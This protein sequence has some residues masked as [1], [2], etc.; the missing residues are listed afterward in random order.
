MN[1]NYFNPKND[2]K[3]KNKYLIIV[4]RIVT[5][6]FILI[7]T[8]LISQKIITNLKE[9]R[10]EPIGELIEVEGKRVFTEYTDKSTNA[11]IVF[12]SDIGQPSSSWKNTKELIEKKSLIDG[13]PYYVASLIYDKPGYGHSDS[14]SK[15]D[16]LENYITDLEILLKKANYPQPY[17]LVG[18]GYGGLIAKHFAYKNNEKVSGMVLINT[19]NDNIINCGEMKYAL[20]QRDKEKFK[21]QALSMSGLLQFDIVYNKYRNLNESVYKEK[22]SKE[23][24]EYYQYYIR[25]N[26]TISSIQREIESLKTYNSDID[27]QIFMEKKPVVLI[28]SEYNGLFKVDNSEWLKIQEKNTSISSDVEIIND[29][30][31]GYM[32]PLTNPQIIYD[33]IVGVIKNNK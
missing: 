28:S 25:S 14:L 4:D 8:L 5:G 32:I 23:D 3:G 6:M 7:V 30:S 26:K 10:F 18:Q 17:I 29:E 31:S 15:G 1:Y 11:T 33:S 19:I 9:K 21:M 16:T 20:S 2:E 13:R 22:L 12:L 24:Y 27:K